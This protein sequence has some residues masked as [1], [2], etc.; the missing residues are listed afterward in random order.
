MNALLATPADWQV[1]L[2]KASQ[3]LAPRAAGRAKLERASLGKA[4]A[5]AEAK[6]RLGA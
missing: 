1:T 6:R 2:V 5:L 4:H 3:R